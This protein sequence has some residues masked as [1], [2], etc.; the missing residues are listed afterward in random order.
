MIT[1]VHNSPVSPAGRLV[2][3]LERADMVVNHV[4]AHQGERLPWKPAAV[5]ILGGEM[6]AFHDGRY[7]YLRDEKTWIRQLMEHD[8]PILGICLGAQLLADA[9]GGRAYTAERPEAG[10]IDLTLTEAGASDP[11]IGP[12]HSPVFTVHA[13]TFDLPPDAVL[14]A[15]SSRFPHAFRQGPALG[16]QFHPEIPSSKVA[17]WARNDLRPVIQ[18]AG[19]DPDALVHQVVAAEHHLETEAERLFERW[20]STVPR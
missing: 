6:S 8:T 20:L 7:P 19:T 10:V 16:I 2:P 11:V 12:L 17:D 9:L 15:S 14:L 18:A 13:D 4:R 3:V 1:V 5:V